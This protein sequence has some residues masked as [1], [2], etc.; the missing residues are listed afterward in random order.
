MD[1]QVLRAS[2][3]APMLDASSGVALYRQLYEEMRQAILAGSLPAGVKLPSTRTLAQTLGVSRAT[4]VLAFDQLLAEGYIYGK[5]GSG[6]YVERVLP[7]ELLRLQDR[8]KG[9][10]QTGEILPPAQPL[11][12]RGKMIAAST[13]APLQKWEQVVQHQAFR[14]GIPALHEF[15][16]KLWSQLAAKRWKH[17]Q[18]S[19]FG[20]SDPAGYRPLRQEIARYL[21][22][23]RGVRCTE[24]QIIIM[25]GSQ[26]ALHLAAQLLIDPGDDVWIED[27]CYMGA[28]GALVSS[29]AQLV[30]VPID[31]EGLAVTQG[32]A[33]SPRARMAYVT[34]SHQ[35]P[36]GTVMSLSRR[37]ALLRW[38][39]QA[40]SWI[41]EDDYDSEY[42]YAGHPLASLQGLDQAGRVIYIGTFSKVLFPAL[43]LGYLVS[44]PELIDAFRAARSAADRHAHMLDQMVTTDFM[45]QEHFARHVRRM[46]SLY[47][48]RQLILLEAARQQ[49][50]D[51]VCIK[52]ATAGMN[53]LA[54]L[55]ARLRDTEVAQQAA[56]NGVAVTPISKYYIQHPPLNGLLLG[57]AAYNQQEIQQGMQNLARTLQ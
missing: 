40:G 41:L 54:H 8:R 19:D 15:P 21:Q 55:P 29:G 10:Q 46:R 2:L 31:D 35:F 50:G 33:I 22:V 7:D 9:G 4:V 48:E 14:H 30:P 20:Y 53:V 12:E 27:P 25:A 38:A 5:V 52:S 43:R 28:R 51:N 34:P 23:A 42:R 17:I 24:E 36:I 44:P 1:E 3:L 56:Q 47:E 16:F 32:I 45:A 39:D 37:L 57:Y 13:V 6:T 18:P 11:S 26:Q 49:L